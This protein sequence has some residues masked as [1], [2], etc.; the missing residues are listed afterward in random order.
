MS[1]T[2]IK[3]RSRNRREKSRRDDLAKE[4]L[5]NPS[6][7]G[8]IKEGSRKSNPWGYLGLQG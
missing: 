1:D 7:F 4:G 3:Q 5:S 6:T 8:L 2:K